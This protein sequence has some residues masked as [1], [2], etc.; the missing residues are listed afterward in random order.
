MGST[1]Q[2]VTGCGHGPGGRPFGAAPYFTIAGALSTIILVKGMPGWSLVMLVK[3]GFF[4]D[5]TMPL[6]D[7]WQ[8]D[9]MTTA[10]GRT[11]QR[12]SSDTACRREQL[13]PLFF[14]EPFP[15][16]IDGGS[17]MRVLENFRISQGAAATPD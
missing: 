4:Q 15:T 10:K 5:E 6:L 14:D 1:G 8:W 12:E 17:T 13:E 7:V 16:E 9:T 2:V 11:A 3:P